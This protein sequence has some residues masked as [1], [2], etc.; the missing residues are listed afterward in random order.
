M[1]IAFAVFNAAALARAVTSL[2]CEAGGPQCGKAPRLRIFASLAVFLTLGLG[3]M[4]F[5][6]E[7]S[8]RIDYQKDY[9]YGLLAAGVIIAIHAAATLTTY[10]LV[11]VKPSTHKMNSTQARERLV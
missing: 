7:L 4:R 1:S 6:A 9:L 5:V 11:S 2:R 8:Y 3:I 10:F